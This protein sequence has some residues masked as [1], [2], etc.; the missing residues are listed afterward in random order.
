MSVRVCFKLIIVGHLER[1]GIMEGRDE[2]GEFRNL[3]VLF[4]FVS[5]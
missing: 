2:K 3:Y 4:L 5:F 1:G